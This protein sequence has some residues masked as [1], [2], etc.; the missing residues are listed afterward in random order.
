MDD[1]VKDVDMGYDATVSLDNY[2]K[3][4]TGLKR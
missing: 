3:Y 1:Y 2:K 4:S